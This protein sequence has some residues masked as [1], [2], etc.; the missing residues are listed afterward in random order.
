MSSTSVT[1]MNVA[2]Q[3]ISDIS[4]DIFFYLECQLQYFTIC[5][6][7]WFVEITFFTFS[8]IVVQVFH[9]ST[10]FEIDDHVPPKLTP[11]QKISYQK[12]FLEIVPIHSFSEHFS[13]SCLQAWRIKVFRILCSA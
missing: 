7:N 13:E 3:N 6:F 9:F 1:N 8:V 2:C 5:F 12:Y 4:R 10:N 11:N